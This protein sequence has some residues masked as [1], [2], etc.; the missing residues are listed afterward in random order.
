M[1]TDARRQVCVAVDDADLA[2]AVA[3]ALHL[4][5]SLP[6]KDL[7]V[8]VNDGHVTLRGEVAWEYQRAAAGTVTRWLNGVTGVSNLIAV[9][10][11]APR[12]VELN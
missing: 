9:R 12:K 5:A 4:S 3:R 10:S 6:Q 1:S 11:R 7:Y 2:E 8:S